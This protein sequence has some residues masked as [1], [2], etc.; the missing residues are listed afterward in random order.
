MADR[1]TACV[2]CKHFAS[3]FSAFAVSADGK[4]DVI[5]SCL[6]ILRGKNAGARK[7]C[8]QFEA[9]CDYEIAERLAAFDRV[10]TGAVKHG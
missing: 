7:T 1:S 9:V 10:R 6:Y 5:G 8:K 4:A 2:R 3:S